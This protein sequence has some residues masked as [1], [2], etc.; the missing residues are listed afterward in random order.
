LSHNKSLALLPDTLP[1]S[2]SFKYG[3]N[4]RK[5]PTPSCLQEF[6]GVFCEY[7]A[8]TLCGV[9]YPHDSAGIAAPAVAQERGS[10]VPIVSAGGCN[11]AARLVHTSAD[12]GWRPA[13][14]AT[15]VIV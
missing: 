8:A 5:L 13:S 4:C 3:L 1:D 10:V 11:A 12:G 15:C 7:F 14:G 2:T 6:N 9:G